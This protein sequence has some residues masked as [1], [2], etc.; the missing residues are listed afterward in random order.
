MSIFHN[1]YYANGVLGS[2]GIR[3]ARQDPLSGSFSCTETGSLATSLNIP[4]A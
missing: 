3:S 4:T 2:E 1:I